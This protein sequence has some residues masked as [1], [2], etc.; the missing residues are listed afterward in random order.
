MHISQCHHHLLFFW[1]GNAL[2]FHWGLR[3]EAS[4]LIPAKGVN[5]TKMKLIQHSLRR[6]IIPHSV[7]HYRLE[8]N[9]YRNLEPLTYKN[10]WRSEQFELSIS[11]V[12]TMTISH[13]LLLP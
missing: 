9:H 1:C 4:L 10:G 8:E 3:D 13:L 11:W 2:E 6:S 5:T 12:F 7:G